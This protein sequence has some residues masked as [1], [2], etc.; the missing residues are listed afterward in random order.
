M[1]GKKYFIQRY[2]QL[3]WNYKP[4][5]PR[6]A[7][8][9]NSSNTN[10]KTL[11]KRLKSKGV[12]LEKIPFLP[13]G[14]WITKT[15]FSIGATVEYLL[16]YYSIQEA[17]SQIPVTLFT[18]LKHK[19]VL[20]ACAAPGGK[21]T[22]LADQMQNKGVIIAIDFKKERLTALTNQIER[23]QT[24]NTIAY[25]LDARKATTLNMKFDRILLDLPCSGN[26]ATD[27]DW[28]QKRTIRDI[29]RNALLQRQ[30]LT[31]TA[32]TLKDN[33]EIIY[34]TCSLEPEENEQ[35]INWAINNL[36][37][38]IQQIDCYG[39]KASTTIQETKLHP[40]IEKCKRIWPTERT[41]GFFIAKL[42][43]RM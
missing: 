2:Q 26:H 41:Q 15:P 16:G 20:D 40:T 24:R 13:H 31:E 4:T 19:L 9:I 3:G 23:C 38:E 37:L 22:Q 32:R 25:H 14:Y 30:I 43:K 12:K 11:T 39:Q 6:Q 7:I 8:R 27:K 17:A 35:N 1:I 36:N 29:K 10:E 21:T 34:A 18:D 33:G 5:K 28:F 42:K